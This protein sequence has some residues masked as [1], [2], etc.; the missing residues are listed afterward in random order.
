MHFIF[1]VHDVKLSWKGILAFLPLKYR[2]VFIPVGIVTV[3]FNPILLDPTLV[4]SSPSRI[5]LTSADS[6]ETFTKVNSTV[7]LK[8]DSGDT[9]NNGRFKS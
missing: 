1:L 7:P 3:P 9:V 2:R 8:E 6:E 5:T 4:I